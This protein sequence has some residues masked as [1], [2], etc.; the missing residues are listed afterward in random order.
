MHTFR[1]AL[2]F[3]ALSIVSPVGGPL[4]VLRVTPGSPASPNAV[5]TVT[6]DRPVAGGLDA[7][8]DARAIFSIDPAVPG[9]IEWRDPVTL[10]FTPASPLTPG[11]SYRIRIDPAFQAMD[12]SRLARAYEAEFRV[13]APRILGGEPANQHKEGRHL[14]A[15]PT[16][17][18][19]VS[20]PVDAGLVE[21][22]ASIRLAAGCGADGGV[23]GARVGESIAVRVVEQRRVE[24]DD[25]RYFIYMGYDGP[26][27]RDAERD[28]RRVVELEPVEPLPLACAG[29]LYLPTE[30]DPGIRERTE[31]RFRTYDPLRLVQASCGFGGSCPTGPVRIEFSTPVSGAE[32]LRRV[33]IAPEIP[34]TLSDTAAVQTI[35]MLDARLTPRQRY[36][37]V[38]D[39]E[40][41]D[42][43]GQRLGTVGVRAF[44]S[45]GYS[46]SVSYEFGRLLV[47][48]EGLRTL[49]VQHVNVDTL[50]VTVVPVPD[51]L[52]HAFLGRGWGW[53]EPWQ[54]LIRAGAATRRMVPVQHAI[55]ER[56]VTGVP[57]LPLAAV[58][59]GPGANRP[60]G[61][62]RAGAATAGAS[63]LS[64]LG[65]L[66]AVA[67]SSPGLD[68][69]ARRHRP[70]ALV[71][72][73]D[74]ALH[75]RVGTDQA[76]AWV[77]GVHDGLPRA[78]ADVTLY[79]AERRIRAKG[80]TDR[81]GIARLDQL[82]VFPGACQGWSCAD[83]EGYMVAELGNDRTIVGI[84]RYDPDLAPWRFNVSS[85]WG[86][87]REPAAGAVFTERGIY[88]PGEPVYAKAIV[89][90]GPLGALH[91]PAPGDSVRWI[92]NDREGGTLRDT[93]VAL[94]EF[95]TADQRLDLP[96]GLPLGRYEAHV[97][98]RWEG[99]WRTLATAQY[100]VAEYRPPEFLVDVEADAAPRFAGDTADARIAA[101]YLFGAPMAHAPVRWALRQ[102][103]L[104]P[105]EIR[106]PGAEGYQ[107]GRGYSWW[108]DDGG[109][110]GVRITAE[111]A[112][113]L[114]ATGRLDL[115]LPLPEPTGGRAARVSILANVTDANRQTVA[116]GASLTVHPA[117]FYI[118]AK[119]RGNDYFWTAGRPV[120]VELIAVRPDGGREANG[121]DP[122]IAADSGRVTGVEINGVL[123][124]REWHRVRRNRGGYV[125]EVGAWVQDTVATCSVRTRA[126]PVGCNFT[127]QSGG[128]YTLTLTAT[129][130]AGRTAA[131]SISRWAA[132]PGWVPW[133]D[134]TQLKLDLIPDRE[135]YA[136]GD[137]AT[138]L[139]ASPFTDAEA[140]VTVERERVLVSHR[141][142]IDDGA[143]TL[144]LPITEEYAPNA[145]VSVVVV[146]GRS[147]PPGPLDDPGRPALRVGYAELRVTPEVK[148]LA[149]EV[150]PL[151]PEYR[152]G[153]TATVRVQVRDAAGRGQRAEV[154]LWA[155]DEGVL[156]LTGYQT[157][158]PIDLLY[159]P[160]G[161][162]MRLASNL[163][164]V[165]AQVPDGQKGKREAGG[166]G[167][168]DMTAILRSRFQTSAFF[169]G[170]IVTDGTG[171]AVAR[172]RLP[173]NLTTFRVMAVAVTAG[174]RYGSAHSDLL[175]T[176]PL[177]ARPALPRFLRE[178][179][180]FSAGAVV[181]SRLGG[182]PQVR[183]E[184]RVEGARLE[185][186]SSRTERVSGGRGLDARVDFREPVDATAPAGRGAKGA[187]SGYGAPDGE[188]DDSARFQFSV[189]SGREA[190]AVAVTIPIRPSYAPLA[191]TIAGT[192]RDTATAVFALGDDVDPTRS[193]LEISF[194]ASPLSFL[195]GASRTLRV[196]PYVCTEQIT[197][198]ALPLIALYRAAQEF[199]EPDLAPRDA[200]KEIESTIA[201]I[202]RRQRPDGGIGF[203]SVSDW[204][205]PWLSAYA[206]RVLLEARDAGFAVPDSALARLADY[207]SRSLSQPLR[208]EGGTTHW[209]GSVE[210]DLAERVAAVDLL[211]RLGRPEIAAEN[212]LL[213]QAF[214]LR[215]EDRVLLAEILAR[216]GQHGEAVRLLEHATAA[217]RI[218]GR[219]AVL[220]DSAGGG[221]YFASRI[222]P[223][224]RLLSALLT[225]APS[226]PLIGPLVERIVEQGRTRTASSGWRWN[227][228]DYGYAALALMRYEEQLRAA[229]ES[230]VRITAGGKTLVEAMVGGEASRGDTLGAP[231]Q[232]GGTR[233][234]T[235]SRTLTIPLQGLVTRGSGGRPEL[236]L[237]L[238]GEGAAAFFYLT[239]REAPRG[240]QLT[241][242]DRGIQVERWY[243]DPQTGQPIVTV[244]EGELVR[245]RLRVTVPAERNFVILDDPL[246]AGL[247]A[248]DLSLRTVSPFG[249]GESEF[250]AGAGYGAGAQ[251]DGGRG[252]WSYGRWDAG[253]WSPFDHKELRDD[254][255]IYSA[256]VLWPGS[257][258]ATYLARATTAGTFLYPPAQAEE[259][260]NPGVNGRSGGGEFRVT[261]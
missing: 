238:R 4:Q 146:R 3:S 204:S 163:T 136:V 174:D 79:D 255:V 117:A 65:T 77:T 233:A 133:N 57:L 25:P 192:L 98:T 36:A 208:P 75:A 21:R 42:I 139:F 131:T 83:F 207:L 115:R 22:M 160:R 241:P 155:V 71:Q 39:S 138:I 43:F 227:T 137:T 50:E 95:G 167:G 116:G 62:E 108:D 7:T 234:T 37:V 190:D 63:N 161:V 235:S 254:R 180:E 64:G 26:Y 202:L 125:Q 103:P 182:S 80:R 212:I 144:K 156:A 15:T 55:D 169:L 16:F 260:Y 104:Y 27:P 145:F 84:N 127:P 225:I 220:P 240:V 150:Q 82:A 251:G 72:V 168:E 113:T 23:G 29:V 99:E 90:E 48:S 187:G 256:T 18:L 196:Y 218:E 89:R 261:R 164:A 199:G 247:E 244:R 44:A 226:S 70:I 52:I 217:V 181:N 19:L 121:W 253:L 151:H 51:S 153:D 213:R 219:V 201:T 122:G 173:D 205:T 157:P 171:E 35:W 53:N 243:E 40:L 203:W 132:G 140:W 28:L 224:A 123:V 11:A 176:R 112:D 30:F 101:R 134:E 130:A 175:V 193:T 73:T 88:R 38:V 135:R 107:I 120:S 124:R 5:V 210:H 110:D 6:F 81:E 250:M 46:P 159:P 198:I 197:S 229:G 177:I 1:L 237:D 170:S 258:T 231:P 76:V 206:G 148:R 128:S 142:H 20:A 13:A 189:S 106:I 162:G 200:A 147:A 143:T 97:Q 10:R 191:Q 32:V 8:V 149:V 188:P 126:E 129:D 45:T 14:P 114:D 67:V 179:D 41:T 59:A 93:T 166:G 49:A 34:F 242:V 94:G 195:R 154:T 105:W 92:F 215:W 152:P 183:V 230:R 17:V 68:S 33:R 86:T 9:T 118:G 257:Y 91:A 141:L 259:M 69:I 209:F 194:G 96:Q 85:A 236:R 221:H 74:L 246:P 2:L 100:Q 12:G 61:P 165:A 178:G 47:E 78:G 249:G 248:V 109:Y 87:Q 66:L 186:R 216:R 54:E 252:G 228:Q 31:W 56:R 158:D 24:E 232:P 222:R 184:A 172:A 60:D 223:A 58:P 211:S 214:R 102:Q 119:V 185:G 239:V 111:G 245:V